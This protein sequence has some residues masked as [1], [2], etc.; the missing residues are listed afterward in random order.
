VELHRPLSTVTP[1]LDGDVLAVLARSDSP[2]TTGQLRRV[3][4][5]PS[6]EGIRK[7]LQRLA[8]KGIVR[9]TRVGNAFSYDL[10]RSHLA[11]EHVVGLA[12]LQETFLGRLTEHLKMK[13]KASYSHSPTTADE[14]KKAGRAADALV[15][16]ARRAHAS[17]G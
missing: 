16:K 7:V 14:V 15:E 9:A 13:T 4:A 2:Y 12:R 8:K 3:L 17:S 10:N 11:A 1:T 6:E 5:G